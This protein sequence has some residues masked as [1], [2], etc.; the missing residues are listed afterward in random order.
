MPKTEVLCGMSGGVDSSVAVHLLQKKGLKVVGV[1][2]KFWKPDFDKSC[3]NACC[4]YD[5][6]LQAKSVAVKL[7]IPFYTL[8]VAQEF[9]KHVVDDFLQKYDSG[10][11]PNPCILCNEKIK[12]GL[13]KKK[14][15]EMGIAKIAT[16]HYARVA[17]E[18]GVYQL[19]KGLDQAKDQSYFLYRLPREILSDILFP[20]GELSKKEVRLIA[21]D[22]GLEVANKRDSQE[23]CFV[24]G[25]NVPIFLAK[26]SYKKVTPGAIRLLSGK[27]VGEHNGLTA[28]TLGQR[29]GIKVGGIGPLYVVDKDFAKN[30]LIVT[31]DK[32]D[33]KN[34][35][36]LVENLNWLTKVGFPLDCGVKTRF[37]SSEMPARVFPEGR[38]EFAQNLQAV[39]PGQ[40]AVFYKGDVVLGGGFI[41]EAF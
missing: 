3:E 34:S 26:M 27:K 10:L 24:P 37:V 30:E 8:D 22:L 20:L 21:K 40:S 13:L 14:S 36:C 5:S 4:S 16:G 11:T 31:D 33:L 41:K 23:V 29:K 17:C 28:F 15:E 2:M 1:F 12:F 39:T 18:Q 6:Y 25:N 35:G 32:N 19:K 7:K 9:K 38:V